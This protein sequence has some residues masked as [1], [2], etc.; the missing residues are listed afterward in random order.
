MAEQHPF[1]WR[2]FQAEI[3]LLCVRWYLRYALSYRDLE[4]MMQERGLHVDHTTI[5]RLQ[6]RAMPPN[7]IGVADSILQQQ[8]TLGALMKRLSRSKRSGYTS[9]GRSIYMAIPWI[10]SSVRPEMRK[11]P[12]TS[13]SQ[14]SQPLIRACH[15]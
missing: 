14:R 9:I 4:E 12:S 1:T 3:I 7:L 2:H 8:G 6:S 5:F 15:E 11:P 13:C 10:F